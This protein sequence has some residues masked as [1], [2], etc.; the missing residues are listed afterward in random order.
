MKLLKKLGPHSLEWM[1]VVQY[2]GETDVEFYET[3]AE[4]LE[5]GEKA[6]ADEGS[7]VFVWRIV[8]QS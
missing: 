2:E 1:M 5:A 7:T 6:A 8:R 3:E 4:A